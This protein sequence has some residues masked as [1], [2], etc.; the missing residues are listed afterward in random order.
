[1]SVATPESLFHPAVASSRAL[2]AG[3]LTGK[4]ASAATSTS[5]AAR[6]RR[7]SERP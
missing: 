2:Q 3:S 4:A 6:N 5:P 7:G 1:M